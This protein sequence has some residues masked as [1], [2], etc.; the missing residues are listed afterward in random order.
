MRSADED[1]T[2]GAKVDTRVTDESAAQE[3]SPTTGDSTAHA[4]EAIDADSAPRLTH[5]DRLDALEAKIAALEARLKH[6]L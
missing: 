4:A 2:P 1:K 5:G 3:V 6:W